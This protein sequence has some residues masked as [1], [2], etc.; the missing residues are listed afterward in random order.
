MGWAAK[1][2]LEVYSLTQA[3]RPGGA[4]PA[5]QGASTWPTGLPGIAVSRAL[6]NLDETTCKEQADSWLPADVQKVGAT[7][8]LIDA[9]RAYV[10]PIGNCQG[11][12]LLATD[13]VE[14]DLA[15][16]LGLST[17]DIAILE[18]RGIGPFSA[19]ASRRR[20]MKP[21]RLS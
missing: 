21:L 8:V 4:A 12:H 10:R 6:R 19:A 20:N 13:W 17:F 7:E 3:S 16:G 9:G 11:P 18:L 5:V 2:A 1:V 14:T 15:K